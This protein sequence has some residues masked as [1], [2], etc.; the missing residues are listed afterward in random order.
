MHFYSISYLD[1]II[2]IFMLKDKNEMEKALY[3]LDQIC[4]MGDRV[5]KVPVTAAVG[6]ILRPCGLSDHFLSGSQKCYGI[7]DYYGRQPGTVHS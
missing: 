4:K 7:Q 1:E 2:I 6:Q 5:L 3:H